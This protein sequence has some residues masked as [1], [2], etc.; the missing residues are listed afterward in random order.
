MN[1]SYFTP[2]GTMH[3]LWG[4]S[5]NSVSGNYFYGAGVDYAVYLRPAS[6]GFGNPAGNVITGNSL[7]SGSAGYIG[8]YTTG[9]TVTPNT[10]Y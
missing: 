9:N 1:P 7:W 2:R 10:L 4:S 8:G 3:F 5:N 6:D